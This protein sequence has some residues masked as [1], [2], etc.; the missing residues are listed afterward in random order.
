MY[1]NLNLLTTLVLIKTTI[2]HY[3][4]IIKFY[5]HEITVFGI[6][7]SKVIDIRKSYL[8]V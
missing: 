7:P 1:Y 6:K 5:Q 2:K 8:P 3:S 4:P